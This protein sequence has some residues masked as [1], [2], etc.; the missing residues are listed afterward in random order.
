MFRLSPEMSQAHKRRASLSNEGPSARRRRSCSA[1]NSEQEDESSDSP[2]SMASSESDADSTS[3]LLI[4]SDENHHSVPAL[5]S[6]TAT[7]LAE[8]TINEAHSQTSG[9]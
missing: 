3:Q 8:E 5:P 1:E 6:E 2:S 4:P 9:E 7:T